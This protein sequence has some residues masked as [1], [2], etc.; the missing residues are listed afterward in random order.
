M[1][2]TRALYIGSLRPRG[3]RCAESLAPDRDAATSPSWFA[4]QRLSLKEESC[5]VQT[6]SVMFYSIEWRVRSSTSPRKN[7][8]DITLTLRQPSNNA[9]GLSE[10]RDVRG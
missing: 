4:L 7:N 8:A 5:V 6:H 2:A 3:F 9:C 10:L 1:F